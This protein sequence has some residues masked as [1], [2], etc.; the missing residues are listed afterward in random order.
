MASQDVSQTVRDWWA[1]LHLHSISL[2]HCCRVTG[3]KLRHFCLKSF[4]C[5][6]PL[7]ILNSQGLTESVAT[8]SVS[9]AAMMAT[10]DRNQHEFVM[11]LWND[12]KW[13]MSEW[14]PAGGD[15]TQELMR[16]ETRVQSSRRN[17]TLL[18]SCRSLQTSLW[19]RG[20]SVASTSRCVT[21]CVPVMFPLSC[22]LPNHLSPF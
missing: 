6:A 19:R 7:L 2:I 8:E 20:A 22:P 5:F 14:W 10:T 13:I 15:A 11:S 4:H 18:V 3:L 16:G 17:V 9:L 1:C 21:F 12:A